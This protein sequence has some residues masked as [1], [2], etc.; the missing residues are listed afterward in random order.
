VVSTDNRAVHGDDSSA[1]A[2]EM[3]MPECAELH[4]CRLRNRPVTI[5]VDSGQWDG[6]APP[7]PDGWQRV[8]FRRSKYHGNT[9]RRK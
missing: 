4:G 1:S 5:S 8:E 7:D 6:V 2:P 9:G 3:R